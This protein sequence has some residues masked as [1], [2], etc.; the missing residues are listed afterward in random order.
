MS[1]GSRY[2]GIWPEIRRTLVCER[3]KSARC[4]VELG[5]NLGPTTSKQDIKRRYKTQNRPKR[6]NYIA[7]VSLHWTQRNAYS[8]PSPDQDQAKEHFLRR[9]YRNDKLES[10][11]GPLTHAMEIRPGFL[12]TEPDKTINR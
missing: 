1:S 3:K 6:T 7:L 9:S 2:A 10:N 11:L 12:V 4:V 5:S 8:Q